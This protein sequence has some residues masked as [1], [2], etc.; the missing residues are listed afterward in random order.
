MPPRKQRSAFVWDTAAS[1]FRRRSGQ[2]VGRPVVI[3]A[4][5]FA[6]ARTSREV[7]TASLALRAGTISLR[8][9]QS[10]V[11][12]SLKD[13]HLYAALIARGGRLDSVDLGR[14]G[15]LVRERYQF[16]GQFAADIASGKQPLDG[17]FLLRSQNY[18]LHSRQSRVNAERV[19]MRDVQGM[20]FEQ[21][22]LSAAESCAGCEAASNAGRVPIGTLSPPGTRDCL[23]ACKCELVYSA[24]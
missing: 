8:D 24:A 7:R 6:L 19:E 2:F 10:V 18:V 12:V 22:V 16:L 23:A 15:Q 9:W 11:A 3:R 5:E 4:F 14:V 17:R 20:L 1:R 13:A 21:N